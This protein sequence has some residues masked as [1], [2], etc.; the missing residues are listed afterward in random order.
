MNMVISF[1]GVAGVIAIFVVLLGWAFIWGKGQLFK[2]DTTKD[3]DY[4]PDPP[5]IF[6]K[7]PKQLLLWEFIFILC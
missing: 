5:K 4:D 2:K 6:L 7:F 1:I 3:P